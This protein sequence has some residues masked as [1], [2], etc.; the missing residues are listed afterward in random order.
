[1][2]TKFNRR[3]LL[4]FIATIV[5]LAMALLR[6]N[7]FLEINAIIHQEEV[8]RANFYLFYDFFNSFSVK[9]LKIIKVFLT[10]L[11]VIFM[12]ALSY[13]IINKWFKN[14]KFNKITIWFYGLVILLFLL[15]LLTT[16]LLDLF[17]VSYFFIR[18]ILGFIHS[19][20]PLFLLFSLF[21]Y[22]TKN[23]TH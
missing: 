10:I 6:E 8:N 19:P 17:D 21:F 16:Y 18:K 5:L 13:F 15:I 12:I 4:V 22:L 7:V 14:D 11:F 1:M 23:K 20:I 3:R 2:I 9:K